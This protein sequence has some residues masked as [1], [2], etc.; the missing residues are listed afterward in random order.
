MDER[1][2]KKIFEAQK[3][4]ITEHRIYMRLAARTGDRR[5]RKILENIAGD[6]LEHYRLWKDAT[7][8]DIEPSRLKI[9]LY[10]L[11]SRVLGLSFGLRLMERGEDLAQETYEE[12]SRSVEEAEG[13][14]Q[15]EMRHEELLLECI[16]EER[17]D[18]AGSFVLGLND[19]LVELTG[20]ISGLTFALR[21]TNLIAAAGLITGISA[22]L[23]MAGSEYLSNRTEEES[24]KD[25]L[26]A[27]L[28]TGIAYV[29]TTFFLI[30]PFLVLPSPYHA[31][32][33]TIGNAVVIISLF[34]FYISVARGY[35]FR[36]RFGEMIAISL[37]VA[38]VSFLIGLA[39]RRFLGVE[40]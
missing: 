29:T 28:Y 24:D 27:A 5:N 20:A 26:K 22:S 17:L 19:A 21:D 30:L 35:S 25:P 11:V 33:W 12:L 4:E 18:Y 34:T 16:R 40:V 8:K 13:I 31:L 14:V 36:K 2:K 15:D 38:A 39:V 32:G 23:S 7:G 3:A 1:T 9:F 6:E 37:G 10:V